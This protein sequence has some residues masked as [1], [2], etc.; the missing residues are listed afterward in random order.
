MVHLFIP[1]WCC[2]GTDAKSPVGIY[3][4]ILFRPDRYLRK[5]GVS[6]RF[7]QSMLTK[8]IAMPVEQK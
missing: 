7:F 8:F 1:D 3:P 5:T 4:L 2:Y 6:P